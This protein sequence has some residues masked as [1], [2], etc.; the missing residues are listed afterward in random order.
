MLEQVLSM[1]CV[2]KSWT[3]SNLEVACSWLDCSKENY[4]QNWL[5]EDHQQNH[6]ALFLKKKYVF[7]FIYISELNIYFITS[8][9]CGFCLNGIW[10]LIKPSNINLPNFEYSMA[11]AAM[12]AL[13]PTLLRKNIILVLYVLRRKLLGIWQNSINTY[14]PQ[15]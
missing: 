6:N 7:Q 5:S 14:H 13:V 11:G 10:Y 2:R 15:Y 12:G 3:V 1:I 4:H 9:T 8:V